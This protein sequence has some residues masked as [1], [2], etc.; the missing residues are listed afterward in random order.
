MQSSTS[1]KTDLHDIIEILLK[2]ALKP[3]TKPFARL[4][5]ATHFLCANHKNRDCII[6]VPFASRQLEY[7]SPIYDLA[8]NGIR[9]HN[10]NGNK[11]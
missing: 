8:M 1:N 3:S 9:T 7:C 4:K 2:V 11:H 6:P 5:W 10:F